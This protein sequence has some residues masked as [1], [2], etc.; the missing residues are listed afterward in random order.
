MGA[1]LGQ[2]K[3]NPNITFFRPI[4]KPSF[5]GYIFGD[6]HKFRLKKSESSALFCQLKKQKYPLYRLI[7]YKSDVDETII[8]QTHP[9]KFCTYSLVQIYNANS[10]SN[11]LFVQCFDFDGFSALC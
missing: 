4:T 1:F 11:F 3:Q 10:I 8:Y 7:I 2:L 5:L 9:I 6:G